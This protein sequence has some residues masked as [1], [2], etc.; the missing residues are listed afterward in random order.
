MRRELFERAKDFNIILD[1]VAITELSFSSQYTAAVEAKQVGKA[2]YTTLLSNSD[3]DW[4]NKQWKCCCHSFHYCLW[5]KCGC[6]GCIDHVCVCLAQQEAQRAQFYVE[7]AKQDQRQ[8]IIQA[9]GEAEAAK[10]VS[11]HW[12][13][14]S[15][16]LAAVITAQQNA[17]LLFFW[18][19]V[20]FQPRNKV[21]LYY[22]SV[23]SVQTGSRDVVPETST[24]SHMYVNPSQTA[25]Q[26]LRMNCEKHKYP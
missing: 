24:V 1:D 9:E 2:Q 5:S 3:S 26:V 21:V 15:A 13:G 25:K 8:K 22:V 6:L 16:V 12:R 23:F 10:M 20:T 18:E 4:S 19:A 14:L 11:R 7:K 17:A